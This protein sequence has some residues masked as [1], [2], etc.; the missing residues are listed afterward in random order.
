AIFSHIA[1][2]T[3][4]LKV[5]T[6]DEESRP[7][8]YFNDVCQRIF[9][10]QWGFAGILPLFCLAHRGGRHTPVH[11]SP[12]RRADA[13]GRDTAPARASASLAAEHSI[14]LCGRLRGAEAIP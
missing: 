9:V 3:L 6:L 14:A 8:I 5:R 11:F 12:G 10:S 4:S 1:L 2:T 7:W 13:T